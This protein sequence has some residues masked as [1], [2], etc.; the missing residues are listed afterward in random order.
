MSCSVKIAFLY[1]FDML[2]DHYIYLYHLQFMIC[3]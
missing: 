1:I 3:S 2:P